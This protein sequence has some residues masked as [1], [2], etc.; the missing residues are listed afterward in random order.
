MTQNTYSEQFNGLFRYQLL[1][2]HLFR[3]LA[4][5]GQFVDE[6]MLTYNIQ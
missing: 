3:S 6:W 5:C 2:T 1:N 4:I